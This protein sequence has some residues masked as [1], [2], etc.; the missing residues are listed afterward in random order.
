MSLP[1]PHLESKD[2]QLGLEMQSQQQFQVQKAG[3]G[4]R[5]KLDTHFILTTGQRHQQDKWSLNYSVF[6]SRNPLLHEIPCRWVSLFGGIIDT[7]E[8]MGRKEVWGRRES[9]IPIARNIGDK[10]ILKRDY[11]HVSCLVYLKIELGIT[12]WWLGIH[13]V[14]PRQNF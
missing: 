3:T 14:W 5:Y 7:H 2:P 4:S 8:N 13:F 12:H 10:K 6:P 11:L 1:E 9:I